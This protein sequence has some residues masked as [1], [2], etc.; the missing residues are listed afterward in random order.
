[1]MTGRKCLT[2]RSDRSIQHPSRTSL[3]ALSPAVCLPAI[4][5]IRIRP[6]G[7]L[8]SSIR[9]LR[10]PV[11][12]NDPVFLSIYLSTYI[13][14]PLFDA[15]PFD[16][17]LFSLPFFGLFFY[18]LDCFTPSLAMFSEQG[19]DV[20]HRMRSPC[21]THRCHQSDA[22]CLALMGFYNNFSFNE[23]FLIRRFNKK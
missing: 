11:A 15:L 19:F 9:S 13:F 23:K 22:V 1:M 7:T 20:L 21:V 10:V 16:V 5:F 18:S 17:P 2:P 4:L 8:S 3:A 6:A 12:F 14:R